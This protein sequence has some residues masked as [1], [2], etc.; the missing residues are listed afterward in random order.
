MMAVWILVVVDPLSFVAILIAVAADLL[1]GWCDL[2]ACCA[3]LIE[4]RLPSC[5]FE[6]SDGLDN[7][8]AFD[9]EAH[10]GWL[11]LLR[12]MGFRA[13]LFGFCCSLDDF[14]CC[15]G[16]LFGGGSGFFCW[17]FEA[18]MMAVW[19]LVVVD[20]L[21][22]VAILIAVAADLLIGWC[23]LLACCAGLNE[24]AFDAEAHSGWL[25][26]L[27]TMGF[28]EPGCLGSVAHG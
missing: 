24:A 1:I 7:E 14:G 22:F 2:L 19:I 5:R 21:S 23:D 13:G 4:A 26:L 17:Y 6:C 27:R 28:R 11:A 9:A 20:P 3:G 18:R 10:S 12:T 25:A 8:A 16:V 15:V